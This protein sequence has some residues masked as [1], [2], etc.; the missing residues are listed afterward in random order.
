MAIAH[1]NLSDK[2]ILVIDD[3]AIVREV[4]VNCLRD[5]G[6][7][8]V[9]E[10]ASGQEGVVRATAELPDAIVLD[11]TMPDM[12]GFEVL[13]HLKHNPVTAAIPVVILSAK[14]HLIDPLRL[15]VKLAI[16]KP[17]GPSELIK[18]IAQA[19]KWDIP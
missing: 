19:L 17:F 6:Q 10:A 2:R 3:E 11:L 1:S 7:W 9:S 8:S 18:Q 12:S 15:G 5:L 14:A 4:V 16:D 13:H